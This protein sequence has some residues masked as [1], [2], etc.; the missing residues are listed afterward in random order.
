MEDAPLIHGRLSEHFGGNP[1]V[2]L[3]STF[4]DVDF[5]WSTC[6]GWTQDEVTCI[7]L[8]AR[9]FGRNVRELDVPGLGLLDALWLLPEGME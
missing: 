1:P 3:S 9:E 4:L 8:V 6:G 2:E 7:V 5:V